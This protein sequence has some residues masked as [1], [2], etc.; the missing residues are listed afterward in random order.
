M[1]EKSTQFGKDNRPEAWSQMMEWQNIWLRAIALA[2]SNPEFKKALLADPRVA[3]RKAFDYEVNEAL[4]LSV[5]E[6]TAEE[7]QWNTKGNVDWCNLPNMRLTMPLPP[8]PKI[9]DQAV[10]ISDYADA[11]R[12][13]PF[14]CC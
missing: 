12:T 5:A 7:A 6:V 1:E 10:A 2:W 14:T 11:G 4:D 9:A 13:Y 8:A 3:I